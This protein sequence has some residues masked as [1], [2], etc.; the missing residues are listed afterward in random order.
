MGGMRTGG[1]LPADP[2]VADVEPQGKNIQ[3]DPGEIE[4]VSRYS[5]M[6]VGDDRPVG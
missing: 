2:V 6:G 1:F 5:S 4:A 3:A